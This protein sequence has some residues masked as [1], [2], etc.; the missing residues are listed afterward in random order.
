MLESGKIHRKLP[1]EEEQAAQTLGRQLFEALLPGE[2]RGLFSVSRSKATQEQLLGV[3]LRLHIQAPDLAALPW[4]Y[5]Y[6]ASIGEY[7]CLLKSSPIVR[8]P[9]LPLAITPLTVAPPSRILGMIASPSDQD[10]LEVTSEKAR[11][12]EALKTLKNTGLVE[13]TWLDGQTWEDV[14]EAMW[15]GPWHIFHFIG[16]GAF[17]KR[18]E[19]GMLALA[20]E[21]G[22][23][24]LLGASDLALLLTNHGSIRLALLNACE[25]ATGSRR[26]VFSSTAATLARRGISAVLAMQEDISDQAAV[27]LTRTFYRA[28]TAG[29]PVD[30]ALA[31][32]RAA[33]RIGLR[34]SLEWGTPVLYL[35]APDGV[36]FDFTEKP[37]F[38]TSEPSPTNKA[39]PALLQPT[40]DDA[41]REPSAE[42]PDQ[43]DGKGTVVFQDEA[44]YPEEIAQAIHEC[45]VRSEKITR[46]LGSPKPM[47]AATVGP[48]TSR[49]GTS[50]FKRSFTK[51]SIYVSERWGAHPVWRGIEERFL[52]LDG[53]GGRPGFPITDEFPAVDS[54][55]QQVPSVYQRFEFEWDY[56]KDV[57]A[58]LGVRCGATIYWS[59][60]AGAYATWGGIGECFEHLFGTGS[61]LGFPVSPELETAPSSQ[62]TA[63][64]YQE[65]EGGSIYWCGR[66]EHRGGNAI[67]GAIRDLYY[68]LGGTKSP[69]GFPLTKEY[70][71]TPSPQGM[72]GLCQRFEG[73]KDYPD[74]LIHGADFPYGGTIYWSASYG[75]FA[76]WGEIGAAYERLGGTG[77]VLGFPVANAIEAAPSPHGINGWYQRFEG[78]H[79]YWCEQ[80]G[81][82]PV[83]EPILTAYLGGSGG[84][85]GFP[86]TAAFVPP[87]SPALRCQEFEGGMICVL[88]TALLETNNSTV[89]IELF[90]PVHRATVHQ[91]PIVASGGR[92]KSSM[93]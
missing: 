52:R 92:P 43:Q 50:G 9:E 85:F 70:S 93:F 72:T 61:R 37:V 58:L 62:G 32:A 65:F 66:C 11:M 30:A 87:E 1:T 79:L 2:A 56:P 15:R 91:T 41:S 19:E 88:Q 23:T 74:D 5:L 57:M 71:A 24:H 45:Y 12:E 55:A 75:A 51:G 59:E 16:H 8:Y 42:P 64:V 35:R 90:S 82:F 83:P 34:Q 49:R 7:L 53:L 25:G 46:L 67:W 36:L 38:R 40:T 84:K 80:Y 89:R 81:T 47:S 21:Q 76:T 14:Q 26:D 18:S 13:L 60:R 68:Q 22:M 28:L 78:G 54:H 10:P 17:D 39:M 48:Y 29:M 63:G 86:I 27:R 73:P 33:I 44:L 69:L 3:R 77:S 6:D 4:E 20:D 31:E